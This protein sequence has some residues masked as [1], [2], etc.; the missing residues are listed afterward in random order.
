MIWGVTIPGQPFSGNHAN[1]RNAGNMGWHKKANVEAYQS[2]VTL[3][4]REAR[5]SYWRPAGQIIIRFWF[6]ILRDID[7]TNMT[8]VIEDAIAAALRPEDKRY[9]RMFL[10][11]SMAKVTGVKEPFVRIELE[12]I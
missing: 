6:H 7:C 8:K 3:L 9:D 2:H 5:P 1:E 4:V 12:A 10:P 11:Q